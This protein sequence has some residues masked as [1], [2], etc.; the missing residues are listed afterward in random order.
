MA[1]YMIREAHCS[2]LGWA[3]KYEVIESDLRMACDTLDPRL[4][5]VALVSGS[6]YV[7]VCV[8]VCVCMYVAVIDAFSI[9]LCEVCSLTM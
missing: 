1:V 5:M 7:C 2:P 6:V 8:C 9:D 3:R 4:D